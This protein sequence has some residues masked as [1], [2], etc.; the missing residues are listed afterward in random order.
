VGR[1]ADQT[2]LASPVASQALKSAAEH[3]GRDDHLRCACVELLRYPPTHLPS[4]LLWAGGPRA[5]AHAVTPRYW[6][7]CLLARGERGS[8]CL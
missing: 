5:A 2:A 4:G 7:C 6:P 1:A 3:E 8:G